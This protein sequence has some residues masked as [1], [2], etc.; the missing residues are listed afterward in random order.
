L[1]EEI[2]VFTGS[3]PA[4]TSHAPVLHALPVEALQASSK[5]NRR[6]AAPALDP[7]QKSLISSGLAQVFAKKTA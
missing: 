1:I 6:K 2:L 5:Q 7:L 4:Y 3:K